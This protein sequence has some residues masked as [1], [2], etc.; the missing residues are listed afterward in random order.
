MLIIMIIIKIS[1]IYFFDIFLRIFFVQILK[2][3]L[4][5]S[6]Y[7]DLIS[8]VFDKI[9]ILIKKKLLISFLSEF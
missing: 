2:L 6:K 1:L 3:K 9:T 5:S 4:K 7:H 8:K